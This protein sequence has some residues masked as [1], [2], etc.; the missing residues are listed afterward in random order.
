MKI[1]KNI[2]AL[3]AKPGD[4]KGQLEFGALKFPCAFGQ[5]G[6]TQSKLEGDGGT[7]IGTWPLRKLYYRADR[8]SV[9]ETGLECIAIDLNDG[10]CDD[11]AVA[12]YNKHVVLPFKPSHEKLWRD[13]HLYDLMIPMGY[14]DQP[15]VPGM[16]SA[17]FFHLAKPDYQPTEGC[18]AISLDHMLELLPSLGPDASV[19]VRFAS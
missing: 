2:L 8:M 16:G 7:P 1:S 19:E 14:N 12:E 18:L 3:V 13:D 4:T 17:I 9:P 6:L 15:I 11:P 10:W 5:G